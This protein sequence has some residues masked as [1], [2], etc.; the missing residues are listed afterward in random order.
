MSRLGLVAL[1][2][3]LLASTVAPGLAQPHDERRGPWRGPHPGWEH[4]D[5]WRHEEWRR[6][7][8]IARDDWHRG[9]WIDYRPYRLGAPPRGYEWR[10]IDGRFVLAAIAGGLIADVIL[11]AH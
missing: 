8:Y 6:G 5:A 1:S 4:Q 10:E 11:H 2:L 7:G 9:H 3:V